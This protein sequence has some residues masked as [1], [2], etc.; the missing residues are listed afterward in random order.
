MLS[1]VVILCIIAI[2]VAVLKFKKRRWNINRFVIVL[3][4][5]VIVLLFLIAFEIPAYQM[6]KQYDTG[7]FKSQIE[8][9][10][11]INEKMEEWREEI[12]KDLANN[13]ELLKCVDRYLE[14]EIQDNR[15]QI[16]FYINF[17]ENRIPLY[18]WCLYFG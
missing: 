16:E 1:L 14:R 9:F 5:S 12:Q 4:I 11:Q 2:V 3:A 18:R 15:K 7:Y 8:S 17:Q 10:T 6:V 13:P